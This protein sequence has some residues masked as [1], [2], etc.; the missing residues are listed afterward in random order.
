MTVDQWL[1]LLS[2][3]GLA[4]VIVIMGGY[5]A[6]KIVVPKYLESIRS[7]VI[8]AAAEA[9][10]SLETQTQSLGARVDNNTD[11]VEVLSALTVYN[12]EHQ[13]SPDDFEEK[14]RAV[15]ALRRKYSNGH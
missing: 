15:R 11:A 7:E 12:M 9:K 2:T 5:Y 8:K 14:L 13:M 3:Q 10:T 4:L 6:V 1:N